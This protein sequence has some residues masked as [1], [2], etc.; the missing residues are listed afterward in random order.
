VGPSVNV[1]PIK[2]AQATQVVGIGL[3]AEIGAD[4]ISAWWHS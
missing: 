2:A 4:E 1:K 3:K